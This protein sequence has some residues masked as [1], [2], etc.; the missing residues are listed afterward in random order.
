MRALIVSDRSIRV[1]EAEDV[2]EE[3]GAVQRAVRDLAV[4][5]G[6]DE[7]KGLEP[8]L[9]LV[10]E[11]GARPCHRGARIGVEGA[12]V[13]L[14]DAGCIVVALH[15]HGA[16]L[17]QEFDALT[18]RGPVPHH[19]SNADERVDALLVHALQHDAQ[20]REVGVDVAEDPVLH[21]EDARAGP[22]RRR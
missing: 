16:A 21:P 19:V 11:D 9:V 14:V 5:E 22:V 20:R 4:L 2:V 1:G 12:L 10:A 6:C 18:R 3:F 13:E 7:R 15:D 17:A 8:A